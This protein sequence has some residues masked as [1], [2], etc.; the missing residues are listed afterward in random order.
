MSSGSVARQVAP[1][2]VAQY[3]RRAG[4]TSRYAVESIT[5]AWSEAIFGQAAIGG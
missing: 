1:L 2:G 4:I 5:N 3:E